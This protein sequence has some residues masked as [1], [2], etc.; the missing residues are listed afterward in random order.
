MSANAHR[1]LK[2][3]AA[4]ERGTILMLFG[5]MALGLFFSAGVAI[6]F[7]RLSHVKTRLSAAADAAALAGGRALLDGRMSN[8]EIETLAERVFLANVNNSSGSVNET[9]AQPA[10]HVNRAQGIIS[11]DVSANVPMTIMK[12]AGFNSVDIPINAATRFDQRDIE[13]SMALDLT[14]S[15][16][17][18]SPSGSGSKMDDLKAATS[19]LIDILLPNGGTPN[20]VRIAFAPY[21]SGVN[22][23]SYALAATG[24][25]THACAFEREGFD[26]LG[27]QA[28]GPGDYLKTRGDAGVHAAASCPSASPVVP[29]SADKAMLKATVNGYTTGG[30]TAGHLGTQWARYLVSPEWNGVFG[31]DPAANY[32]DGRTIKAV[33]LMTDGIFNTVGGAN[34]GDH[35]YEGRQSRTWTEQMCA[36]M[37]TQSVRVYTVG[38]ALDSIGHSGLRN[39]VQRMLQNCAGQSDRYFNAQ[40]GQQLRAAFAAIAQQLNN[41]RLTN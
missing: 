4:N 27:E 31:G 13:L 2:G 24:Q 10:I 3:F 16:G 34:Y 8:A 25:T 11:I 36:D 22:A 21:S 17:W 7:T 37:R 32:N 18:P 19:D 23:G 30:S 9:F 28:P 35:S 1:L 33:V 12:I 29:L 41:L 26:P 15:M 20:K 38:F 14:G 6:D 5:L 40:D 39:D